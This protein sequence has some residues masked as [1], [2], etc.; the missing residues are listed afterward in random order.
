MSVRHTSSTG[1]CTLRPADRRDADVS[2]V[3]R[4]LVAMRELVRERG[5]LRARG[6]DAGELAGP[7][8]ALERLRWRLACAVRRE[9]ADGPAA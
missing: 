1:P 4:V 3:E 5:R 9:L 7:S 2:E 6:A 8:A